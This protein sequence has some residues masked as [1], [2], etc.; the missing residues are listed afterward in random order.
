MRIVDEED[1]LPELQ[2]LGLSRPLLRLAAGEL[3][4]EPFSGFRVPYKVYRGMAWD[5]GPLSVPLWEDGD[6]TTAVRRK[7]KGLEFFAFS[8][9]APAEPWPL[10]RTEQGLLATLFRAPLN[11]WYDDPEESGA[12]GHRALAA[13]ARAVGFRLFHEADG[14]FREQ[15]AKG[16]TAV[17]RAYRRLVRD[18]DAGLVGDA[19]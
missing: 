14:V 11:S 2:R 17:R 19:E 1:R 15:F 4:P 18:I 16:N 13:A 3:R 6:T 5:S 12:R 9:E 10:A 8:V 7:G